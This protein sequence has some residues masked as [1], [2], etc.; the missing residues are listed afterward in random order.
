MSNHW[1]KPK[2]CGCSEKGTQMPRP[3][4]NFGESEQHNRASLGRLSWQ[5][6]LAGDHSYL[7]TTDECYFTGEYEPCVGPGMKPQILDLKRNQESVIA[8]LALQ[9][10]TALPPE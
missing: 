3:L 8:D 5:S 6:L 2:T 4:L 1:Q 10:M 9:L 7:D